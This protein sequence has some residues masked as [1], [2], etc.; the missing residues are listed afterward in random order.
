MSN[1]KPTKAQIAKATKIMTNIAEKVVKPVT[2]ANKRAPGNATALA[3]KAQ[4]NAAK[5]LKQQG[6]SE[7]VKSAVQAR[8]G[9]GLVVT[10]SRDRSIVVVRVDRRVNELTK[11]GEPV[12]ALEAYLK[13]QPKPQG[14]LAHGVDS[15]NSP[16]AAKA[17]A[18]QRKAAT[19]AKATGKGK[20]RAE[21]ASKAKQPARGTNRR[22]TLA[23]R[24]DE[25]KPDTF[26]R[27]MLATIMGSKDTD[28]AKAKH[29]KSGKYPTHKLDFN[30]SA[31]QGYIKFA[32]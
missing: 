14:K 17:V 19:P 3:A 9:N 18:D 28:S 31:Q 12:A 16:H 21:K 32:D 29:A 6:R 4:D 23:G 11:V 1:R 20:V 15:H 10:T 24:K 27:Y 13:S 2:R 22:Y 8:T 25:S 5:L 7:C 30:W 26:R